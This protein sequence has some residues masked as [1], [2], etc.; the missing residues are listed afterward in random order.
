MDYTNYHSPHVL[1]EGIRDQ[2]EELRHKTCVL[3]IKLKQGL[4]CK[5]KDTVGISIGYSR[6]NKPH[7]FR[8]FIKQKK[9]KTRVFQPNKQ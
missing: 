5:H 2:S 3:W 4:Q 8:L 9:T 7:E 6:K 1:R